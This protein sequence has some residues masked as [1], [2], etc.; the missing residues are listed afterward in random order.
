MSP[1]RPGATIGILGNGQ[2]GRML[3]RLPHLFKAQVRAGITHEE[4]RQNV[5][6]LAEVREHRLGRL[7]DHEVLHRLRVGAAVGVLVGIVV[8]PSGSSTGCRLGRAGEQAVRERRERGRAQ[9]PARSERG[10]RGVVSPA[11]RVG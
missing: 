1:L 6:D 3:A 5:H 11:C 10:M 7:V 2:L 9:R 4:P 8:D